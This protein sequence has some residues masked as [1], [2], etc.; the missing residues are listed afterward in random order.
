MN[1]CLDGS[2]SRLASVPKLL[3]QLIAENLARRRCA[4]Y[5]RQE[6]GRCT[7]LFNTLGELCGRWKGV[8]GAMRTREIVL[9]LL[10]LL[11]EVSWRSCWRSLTN[12]FSSVRSNSAS[13]PYPKIP[14]AH[15]GLFLLPHL[16]ESSQRL[17][18]RLCCL[19]AVQGFSQYLLYTHIPPFS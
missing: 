17:V 12:W 11:S 1:V 14:A 13:G 4:D 5:L 7:R 10:L 2:R 8:S 18:V 3:N 19:E 16:C 6:L 15:F 9:L